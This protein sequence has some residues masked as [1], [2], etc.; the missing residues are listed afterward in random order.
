MINV[1]FDRYARL[2]QAMAQ[3]R[4][5]EIIHLLRDTELCVTDIYSML[6]LPQANISQHLLKLRAEGIV[7]TRRHGKH[8]YY[9]LTH[10]NIIKAGDL[11]KDFLELDLQSFNDLLPLVHDPV[12]RMQLS[13]KTASFKFHYQNQHYYF[14]ASGC[15]EKFQHSPQRYL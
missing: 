8:I 12:C 11:L 1:L 4:R 13:P 2:L 7:K 15:Y 14:C 6:D 3:S 10:P 5:L 9:S